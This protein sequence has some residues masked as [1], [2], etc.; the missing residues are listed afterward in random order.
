M[1]D[2]VLPKNDVVKIKYF[3]ARV[4]S[5]PNNPAQ[6]A[7]QE[8]YLRALRTIPNLEIIFGR[9]SSHTVSMVRANTKGKRP[10]Y[11]DVLK[12]EEK[13]SD[14]NIATDM[15]DDGCQGLYEVAVLITNDSDLERTV[16]RVRERYNVPVGIINPNLDR[17][18][19][20]ALARHASFV[21]PIRKWH[22]EQSQFPN[23]IRVDEAR[24]S[25]PHVW[26]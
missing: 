12:T 10:Q 8:L 19:S 11:V 16:R 22:L 5:R 7:R 9:F 14:V 6:S 20:Q 3:S 1:C 2:L 18:A 26:R 25:K 4:K 23:V 15:M 21:K 17:P 24:I 13:G